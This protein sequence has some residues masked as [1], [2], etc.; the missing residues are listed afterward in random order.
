V[1]RLKG[2]I[3]VFVERIAKF[4]FQI[5]KQFINSVSCCVVNLKHWTGFKQAVSGYYSYCH[6]TNLRRVRWSAGASV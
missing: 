2:C 6:G 1:I 4:H 5:S 3:I